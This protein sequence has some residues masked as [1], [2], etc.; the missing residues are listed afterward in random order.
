MS[1]WQPYLIS[2]VIGLLVGIERE[3]AHPDKKAIGVRTLLLIS[4]LGAVAGG[5]GNPW[6][7]AL[8]TLFALGLILVS[9]FTTARMPGGDQDRGLT[10]EFAAGIVFCLGYASHREPALSAM[11]GP[12]VAVILFSKSALHRFTRTIKPSELE[13]ALLLLLGGVAVVNLVPDKVVDPWGIFNPRKFGLLVLTL[14]SVEFCSYVLVKM[15]G[16]KRGALVAGL[17]GGLVSSTAVTVSTSRR[18]RENPQASRALLTSTLAAKIAAF[19]ALIFVVG[20]VSPPL[21]LRVAPAVAVGILVC[22]VGA[23]LSSRKAQGVTGLAL[24]SPLDWR[25]VFR[26]AFLLG[27]I[28]ACVSLAELWLGEGATYAVS[29]VTGSFELHGV[30]LATATMWVQGKLSA[31]AAV[32]A[33]LLAAVASLLAKVGIAWTLGGGSFARALTAV[34]LSAAVLMGAVGWLV[35]R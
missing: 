11:L 16:E 25:G 21:A 32:V 28:L 15:V 14:A 26:L 7:A 4:L 3:K 33:V 18:A 12:I 13:A 34:F 19:L 24:R 17:L 31:E 10:T 30:S 8:I 29:F 2:L 6:F 1:T 20:L 5:L 23:V 27:G 9:Y 35:I 22:G